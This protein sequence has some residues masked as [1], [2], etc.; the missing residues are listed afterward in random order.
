[1]ASAAKTNSEHQE[2]RLPE[3]WREEDVKWIDGVA[4][5][6]TMA[7]DDITEILLERVKYY[8]KKF[9]EE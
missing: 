4:Y 8:E 7:R 6:I 5:N 3:G 9:M 1:M 2:R